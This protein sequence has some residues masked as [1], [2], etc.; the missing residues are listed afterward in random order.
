MTRKVR[1]FVLAL[2]AL[3]ASG[4]AHQEARA[5]DLS[6]KLCTLHCSLGTI[7]CHQDGGSTTYCTGFAAGCAIGCNL[8]A[9]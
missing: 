9:I 5:D 7:Q 3:A 4:A 8:S 2:T 6:G 1:R